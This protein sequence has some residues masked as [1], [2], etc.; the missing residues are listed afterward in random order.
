MSPRYLRK[1]VLSGAEEQAV[2]ELKDTC[3]LNLANC[4]LKLGNWGAAAADC[5]VVG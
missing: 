4:N 1:G 2:H 3:H 5:D